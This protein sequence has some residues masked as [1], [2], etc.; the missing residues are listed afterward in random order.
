MTN[1]IKIAQACDRIREMQNRAIGPTHS[2]ETHLAENRS[3]SL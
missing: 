1:N 2:R 3:P